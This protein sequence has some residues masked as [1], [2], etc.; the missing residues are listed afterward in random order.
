MEQTMYGNFRIEYEDCDADRPPTVFVVLGNAWLEV[1]D[2]NGDLVVVAQ[3]TSVFPD[4][5]RVCKID[6]ELGAIKL[7]GE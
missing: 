1:E 3:H 7:G 5:K 6:G 4:G 2:R